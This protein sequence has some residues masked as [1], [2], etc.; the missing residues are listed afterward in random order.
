MADSTLDELNKSYDE[1]LS[2][3]RKEE[4]PQAEKTNIKD[5]SK[6]V[7]NQSNLEELSVSVPSFVEKEPDFNKDE[8]KTKKESKQI[9]TSNKRPG[10][11]SWLIGKT[12]IEI[13]KKESLT[14]LLKAHMDAQNAEIQKISDSSSTLSDLS[15]KSAED[16]NQKVTKDVLAIE[17]DF[18]DA[19]QGTTE[20]PKPSDFTKESRDADENKYISAED[21]EK[22][23]F[24]S[25]KKETVEDVISKETQN[26]SSRNFDD[27]ISKIKLNIIDAKQNLPNQRFEQNLNQE[28]EKTRQIVKQEYDSRLNEQK[29]S[30]LDLQK[31]VDE[32]K[33][34]R[35][36]L[37]QG[38]ESNEQ[39][40]MRL[41]ESLTSINSKLE[42][43]TNEIILIRKDDTK[44]D[45]NKMKEEL[46][47][48]K[49]KIEDANT[50]ISNFNN[51]LLGYVKQN[52]FE[53][54]KEMITQIDVYVDTFDD[55]EREL[56]KKFQEIKELISRLELLEVEITKQRADYNQVASDM[57]NKVNFVYKYLQQVQNSLYIISKSVDLSK[58]TDFG[59][60]HNSNDENK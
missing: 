17:Q 31:I 39:K 38:N 32:L 48:I 18:L 13:K 58:Q 53:K 46:L 7:S 5:I 22:S 2:E 10:F 42:S 26:K 16:A 23:V 3:L 57:Q 9:S 21:F 35:N 27:I 47:T 34:E 60:I 36:H 28:I 8:I 41:E 44:T 54:L 37:V 55:R 4:Q 19:E 12:N 45:I 50:N 24:S 56:E 59:S 6:E 15:N 33:K 11:F 1:L 14:D 52:Q 25:V 49:S 30:I 51:S 40:I 43:V 20:E 29:K